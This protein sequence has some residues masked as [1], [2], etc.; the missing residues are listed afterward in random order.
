MSSISGGFGLRI[1]NA[2][3]FDPPGFRIALPGGIQTGY[4]TAI[5]ENSPVKLA[6]G[7][8]VAAVGTTGGDTT[9]GI[10][11]TFMGVEYDDSGG[12]H[13]IS[14]VWKASTAATNVVAYYSN[15]PSI[16][17]EAQA[18]GSLAQT[19]IGSEIDFVSVPVTAATGLC[20]GQLDTTTLNSGS[21]R[22]LRIVGITPG[23]DNAFGDA[24]T[25]VQVQIAKHQFV[26]PGIGVA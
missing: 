17:Y 19:A 21:Q 18:N 13:Q 20:T 25:I 9:G 26:T 15:S 16:T 4:A 23:A 14:N 12:V 1:C 3:G 22:L 10:V 6:G 7:F 5:G 8:L 2:A 24:F 11:G